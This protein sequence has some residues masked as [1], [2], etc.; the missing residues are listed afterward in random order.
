MT[1]GLGLV[2]LDTK[3][4]SIKTF[5][6]T[7][8]LTKNSSSDAE[9]L[10]IVFAYEKLRHFGIDLQEVTVFCDCLGVVNK[11]DNVPGIGRELSFID[12]AWTEI[13]IAKRLG[14]DIKWVKGHA[15]NEWNK[16]ADKLAGLAAKGVKRSD[17]SK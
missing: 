13:M 9:L 10:G 12:S 4:R 14:M 2:I 6:T 15:S 7:R 1:A 3:K 16:M 17:W 8:K 11:T 5:S